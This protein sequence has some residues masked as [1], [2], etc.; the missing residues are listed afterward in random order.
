MSSVIGCP[1]PGRTEE[2]LASPL[3]DQLKTKEPGH[4]SMNQTSEPTNNPL[5]FM[6][7]CSSTPLP[8]PQK[9]VD[10]QI[11]NQ[12]L[13]EGQKILNKF[14]QRRFSDP[15]LS[16]DDEDLPTGEPKY[17]NTRDQQEESRGER[18]KSQRLQEIDNL[19]RKQTANLVTSNYNLR[20]RNQ[21]QIPERYKL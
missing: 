21:L 20:P 2:A 5:T 16:W 7:R 4:P 3:S 18:E 8:V 10:Q 13:K 12:L 11:S 15:S 19:I 17:E 14:K 6:P 1:C 9:I